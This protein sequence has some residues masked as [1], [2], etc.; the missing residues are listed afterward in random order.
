MFVLLLFALTAMPA[1]ANII[2]TSGNS[3]TATVPSYSAV[4]GDWYAAGTQKQISPDG[5]RITFTYES[6]GQANYNTNLHLFYYVLTKPDGSREIL[7]QYQWDER[8]EKSSVEIKDPYYSSGTRTHTFSNVKLPEQNF[9]INISERGHYKVELKQT[10]IP[11][12]LLDKNPKAEYNLNDVLNNW[13]SENIRSKSSSSSYSCWVDGGY[14]C[15]T[16]TPDASWSSTAICST[17]GPTGN[18]TLKELLWSKSQ[19]CGW[20]LGTD[21]RGNP[22]CRSTESGSI[23]CTAIGMNYSES[24]VCKFSY[25]TSSSSSGGGSG[26]SATNTYCFIER[27]SFQQ[28]KVSDLG[29]NAIW[30]SEFDVRNPL[31]ITD[32]KACGDL[33]CETNPSFK[34]N[35][36]IYLSIETSEPVDSSQLIVSG[37]F[38]PESINEINDFDLQANDGGKAEFSNG[39]LKLSSS[40]SPHGYGKAVSKFLYSAPA[41]IKWIGKI[42]PGQRNTY[43]DVDMLIGGD[44]WSGGIGFHWNSWYGYMDAVGGSGKNLGDLSGAVHEFRLDVSEN[45]IVWYIDSQKVFEQNISSPPGGKVFTQAYGFSP[46]A[47]GPRT[48]GS[49]E[50]SDFSSTGKQYQMFRSISGK[51]IFEFTPTEEGDYNLNFFV[52]TNDGRDDSYSVPLSITSAIPESNSSAAI[53]PFSQSSGN[54]ESRNSGNNS[55]DNSN[56]SLPLLAAGLGAAGAYAFYRAARNGKNRKSN[57]L[58][59][60]AE[61]L[62]FNSANG[63]L[64]SKISFNSVGGQGDLNNNFGAKNKNILSAIAG[65]LGIGSLVNNNSASGG[66][67]I[68]SQFG[69]PAWTEQTAEAVSGNWANDNYIREQAFALAKEFTSGKLSFDLF[70]EKMIALAALAKANGNQELANIISGFDFSGLENNSEDDNFSNGEFGSENSNK[71][72]SGLLSGIVGSVKE[73][74]KSISNAVGSGGI[75]LLSGRTRTGSVV[76]NAK[77]GFTDYGNAQIKKTADFFAFLEE[78]KNGYWV[79]KF[80][81]EEKARQEYLRQKQLALERER[82]EQA[83]MKS[84]GQTI[85]QDAKS[86]AL[87][88]AVVGAREAI[89]DLKEGKNT[90]ESWFKE[91]MEFL[92]KEARRGGD[93]KLAEEIENA[94]PQ[95]KSGRGNDVVKVDY[96]QNSNSSNDGKPL[97][98][99][100]GIFSTLSTLGYAY[101]SQG[102]FLEKWRVKAVDMFNR[103]EL[104]I[105]KDKIQEI[106]ASENP[107]EFIKYIITNDNEIDAMRHVDWMKSVAEKDVL[108]ARIA[109][110]G[111]EAQ[112]CLS[113][114]TDFALIKANNLIGRK[115]EAQE[116]YNRYETYSDD[117]PLRVGWERFIMDTH[118]NE[119]GIKI[120]GTNKTAFDLNEEGKLR[121]M[122]SDVKRGPRK[123][124]EVER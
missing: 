25:S 39:I 47:Y 86:I 98:A 19:H 94:S 24:S 120:A 30:V 12:I 48:I 119:M 105:P 20:E 1:F 49:L 46:G 92:A 8:N 81:A 18:I 51:N 44:L 4:T 16:Y 93:N 116:I 7:K 124:E 22:A 108:A 56:S 63:N 60:F 100:K 9:E 53:N 14:A 31:T 109:G 101:D 45:K 89:D 77:S 91:R 74:G 70:K 75:S 5:S 113:C 21:F 35:E 117:N 42:I 33:N 115:R 26:S 40:E 97:P 85:I 72:N 104:Q 38:M 50:L 102:D 15:I 62:G 103:G 84:S 52:S 71:E 106:I 118:N 96:Q 27:S 17:E 57:F 83:Q 110:W 87:Y 123:N 107:D 58:K 41:S 67:N 59:S 121:L 114:F 69:K 90:S 61:K 64:D 111:H 10:T 43:S 88:N 11:R 28:I 55:R 2:E 73:I 36:K 99:F 68:I 37:G 29:S 23:D 76:M 79:K 13:T 6:E 3:Y 80:E 112:Q 54:S 78:E 95:A 34:P 32:V 65:R 66:Q 122:R 82:E